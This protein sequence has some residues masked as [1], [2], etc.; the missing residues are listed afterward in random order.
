VTRLHDEVDENEKN[1]QSEIIREMLFAV[2][3]DVRVVLVTLVEQLCLL[4]EMVV[5]EDEDRLRVAHRVNDIFAPISNLLGIW[6]LKWEL[7]DLSFRL[8]NP[9]EYRW[10]AQNLAEKR[11]DR[12]RY[13]AQVIQLL[14]EKLA[15]N[16]IE[17]EVHGRP[18]HIVSIWRKMERKQVEF[19]E[20]Y[21]IRAIRILVDTIP[22]CYAVLGIAHSL[23]PHIKSEFDDYIAMP[24]GNDYRSLHTAV[25]GPEGKPIEIQVRTHDMDKHS[26]LGVAAHW[27]YKDGTAYDEAFLKKVTRL[28][29]YL[30]QS[31]DD[32]S[33][34]E[35]LRQFSTDTLDQRIYAITPKGKIIDLPKGATPIDFA[36]HIH[37]EVGH[38]C[39]GAKVNGRIVPLTYELKSGD[40]VDILVHSS[41]R[42][43]P[44]WLSLS[45]GFVVTGRARSRIRAWF[46]EQNYESHLQSG[47]QIVE[48]ELR[49][50]HLNDDDFKSLV[51]RSRYKSE[52]DFY[53][54]VGRGELTTDQLVDTLH[55]Y[56]NE[57]EAQSE[58]VTDTVSEVR[59]TDARLS[60]DIVIEGVG[61]LLTQMARCCQPAPYEPI[62]GFITQ[63][64][65]VTIHRQE[66]PNIRALREEEQARLIDVEWANQTHDSYEAGLIVEAY[67]RPGLLSDLTSLLA[68]EKV[69]VLFLNTQVDSKERVAQMRLLLEISDSEQLRFLVEKMS[70]QSG[71]ISVR[72]ELCSQ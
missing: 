59:T 3:D 52:N 58:K 51:A 39:R 32:Q 50:L 67:D 57:R 60:S 5:S 34:E 70:H 4:R 6:Q 53:A 28:R 72:R 48:R 66:C 16:G 13:I 1:A 15:E 2:T 37:S 7:E 49:C 44:D 43:S 69:N 27:R 12:E 17:A 8:L 68:R 54:A 19:D 42:P 22:E 64:R 55:S 35:I 14:K 30:E 11:I 26:E 23:W 9:K 10:I 62:V 33:P 29:N 20:V 36:Y 41:P 24:K 40:R 46:R 45:R 65:G 61:Q 25:I 38:R 56:L 63:G 47:R 18:K 31:V 21:D 71:V